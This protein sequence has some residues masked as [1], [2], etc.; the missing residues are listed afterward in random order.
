[1]KVEESRIPIMSLPA[2]ERPRERLSAFGP[3]T[4]S[5]K[6]LLT[7]ILGS[8]I[9]GNDVGHLAS[10]L[11][12]LLDTSD[13]HCTVDQIRTIPGIGRAKA[14]LVAAALEFSRRRFVPAKIKSLRR[15][16]FSH[17][18]AIL[19]TGLRSNFSPFLSMGPMRLSSCG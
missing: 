14:A 19:Q 6:E 1:M 11:L 7:I 18:S 16:M 10:A 17:W 2:E 4:L 3:S 5:D 12:K 8:G 9:K 13:L 15:L